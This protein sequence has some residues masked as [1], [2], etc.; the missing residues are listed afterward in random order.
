MQRTSEN[1]EAATTFLLQHFTMTEIHR[2]LKVDLDVLLVLATLQ[3]TKRMAFA[4]TFPKFHSMS[5]Y[6]TLKFFFYSDRFLSHFSGILVENT[7]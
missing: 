6:T 3:S 1:Y 4:S 2:R 5:L 7:P